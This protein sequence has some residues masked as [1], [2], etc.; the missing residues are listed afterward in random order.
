M[1]SE[2]SKRANGFLEKGDI[3]VLRVVKDLQGKL[4]FKQVFCDDDPILPGEMGD[5]A[6]VRIFSPH[7][8]GMYDFSLG[9]MWKVRIVKIH[10]T[11]IFL[12]DDRRIIYIRVHPIEKSSISGES[13]KVSDEY[14][15][16]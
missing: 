14:F 15:N 6:S 11:D 12:K 2:N 3:V 1:T 16:R 7:R 5:R 8:N 4:C 13:I 10:R 9:D